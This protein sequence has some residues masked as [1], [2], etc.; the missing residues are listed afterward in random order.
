MAVALVAQ[1]QTNGFDDERRDETGFVA[2]RAM[3]DAAT[4]EA[5]AVGAEEVTLVLRG[6]SAVL[7]TGS[8]VALEL[9]HDGFDVTVAEQEARF[10]GDD[11]VFEPGDEPG[12]LILLLASGR[13]SV[14]EGPGRT[15]A[16]YDLAP[17]LR[18][19]LGP[20]ADAVRGADVVPAPGAR[21]LIEAR[22]EGDEVAWVEAL[23]ANLATQPEEVL[24]DE[25]ALDL[26]EA[27]Y[28]AE[29]VLDLDEV[30][31]LRNLLPAATVNEDDVFEL[32]VLTPAEL[33]EVLPA[34][35]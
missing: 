3:R 4:D 19:V 9:V 13:G 27:G 2:M 16:T 8:A 23:M 24:T 17:D 15:I 25:R 12:D 31:R 6:R 7:A 18:P 5:A 10:W 34:A 21:A 20:L 29:P 32:R 35:E 11:R 26:I 14:P 22:Y 30:A 33:A 1:I 28:L